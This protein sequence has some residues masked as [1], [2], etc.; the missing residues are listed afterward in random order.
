MEEFTHRRLRKM[1]SKLVNVTHQF[2]ENVTDQF[3]EYGGPHP[4]GK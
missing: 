2:A 3:A 1:I 4:A